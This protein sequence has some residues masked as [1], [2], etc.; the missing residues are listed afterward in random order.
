M[1][2]IELLTHITDEQKK[3][4]IHSEEQ[5]KK[6]A[7]IYFEVLSVD[8]DTISLK[9][10]QLESN[11]G[12]YLSASDLTERAK[13]VFEGCVPVG[14]NLHVRAVPFKFL[15]VVELDYIN[16]RKVELGLSDIDLS[17]LL[18]IRKENLSRILNDVRGLT[19]WQKSAFYYLFK[20]LEE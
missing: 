3:L 7:R 14:R 1:K 17:R 13:E 10:H 8:N 2:G 5:Y 20:S 18:D 4:L 15:E 6:F 11:A 12:K 9:V 19:K 16:K